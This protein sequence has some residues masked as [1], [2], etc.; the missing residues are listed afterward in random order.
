MIEAAIVGQE[1]VDGAGAGVR[2]GEH[3]ALP[4]PVAGERRVPAR[5]V[6]ARGARPAAGRRARRGRR[7]TPSGAAASSSRSCARTGSTGR[8]RRF[9]P[10][11]SRSWQECRSRDRRPQ[12]RCCCVFR[13]RSRRG[14]PRCDGAARSATWPGVASG[15]PP[16]PR[17]CAPDRCCDRA[18]GVA[19]AGFD[20]PGRARPL[21]IVF[22]AGGPKFDARP[23]AS[24][25]S[26]LL[27]R[28]HELHFAFSEQP[29]RQR[30]SRMQLA[31]RISVG[32][33]RRCPVPRPVRRLAPRRF[34][35]SQARR[36]RPLRASALRAAHRCC[37]SG[38]PRKTL[39]HLSKAHEYEPL[40]RRLALRVAR[41]LSAATDAELSERA[42]RTLARLGGRN[43]DQQSDRPLPSRAGP[44]VVLVTAV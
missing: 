25:F 32:D 39:E 44:D 17:R 28:G 36:P 20:Q 15:D 16:D 37:A 35:R 31:D 29:V 14:S 41:R 12:G 33:P 9:S 27:E 40:G 6:H 26:E 38:W 24:L 4:L 11:R 18:R 34:P 7:P 2:A 5:R 19:I 23:W 22:F 30:L 21:R 1:R 3:A 8:R 43:P 42:I 13:L 10:T